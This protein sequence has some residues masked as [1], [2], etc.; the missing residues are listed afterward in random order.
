M[1]INRACY[2]LHSTDPIRFYLI[3]GKLVRQAYIPLVLSVLF[4]ISY[5][6]SFETNR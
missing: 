4:K 5:I 2:A 1:P 6:L 3:V